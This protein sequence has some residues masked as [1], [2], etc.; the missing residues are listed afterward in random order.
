MPDLLVKLLQPQAKTGY[1]PAD[2]YW[3]SA[4]S[5][6]SMS[7]ATVDE[8]TAQKISAFYRGVAIIAGTIAGLPLDVFAYH[9]D[10]SRDRATAH[11][12]YDVMHRRPN[13]R[14]TA[15]TGG[16][17]WCGRLSSGAITTA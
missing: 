16:T 10:G 4:R 5:G 2:D 8:E 9:S 3:Y 15:S 11:P 12:L 13:V 1:G 7:G 6:L 17:G 14:D